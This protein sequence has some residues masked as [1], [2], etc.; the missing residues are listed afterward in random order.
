MQ[1]VCMYVWYASICM[2]V[3]GYSQLKEHVLKGMQVGS[4]CTYCS[5]T[6]WCYI[7][8]MTHISYDSY[9]CCLLWLL[10]L[11]PPMTPMTH[12][13]YDSYD[14]CLLALHMLQQDFSI[15]DLHW[16]IIITRVLNAAREQLLKMMQQAPPSLE[17]LDSLIDYYHIFVLHIICLPSTGRE[18][19]RKRNTRSPSSSSSSSSFAGRNKIPCIDCCS[20]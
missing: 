8:D 16:F 17:D 15:G 1:H 4:R 18:Q 20:V 9:D 11:M 19:P 7:G 6:F 14:W 3:F 5:K 13:S 2:W 10:W 12:V